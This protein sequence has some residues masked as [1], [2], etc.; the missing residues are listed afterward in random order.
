MSVDAII[1]ALRATDP[2]RRRRAV[3]RLVQ[4]DPSVRVQLL[5]AA[6]GDEDWRVRKEATAAAIAFA[7]ADDVLAGLI[8]VLGPGDN[9]GQRNAAVE[10]LGGFGIDAVEAL[11][12]GM[13]ALDADGRKLG[14]EALGRTGHV[15]ALDVLERLLGDADPNVRAAAIEAITMVG[16]T[17]PERAARMLEQQMSASERIEALSA[18]EGL[19]RLGV[20]VDWARLLPLLSDPVLARPALLAAGRSARPEAAPHLVRALERARATLWQAA[21]EALASL[22][23]ADAACRAAARAALVSLEEPARRRLI[24]A[25][26]GQSEEVDAQRAALLVVGA[27]ATTEAAEAAI[28]A[29]G[30][31]RVAAEADEALVMLGPAAILAL[32]A[33]ARSGE[34]HERALCVELLGRLADDSTRAIARQVIHEAARDESTE[35]VRAALAALGAIGDDESLGVAVRWLRPEAPAPVRQAAAAALA[36]G[37]TRHPEA[38]RSLARQIRPDEPEATVA[39]IVIRTVE[40]AVFGD[41]RA[42]VEF[43]VQA[44]SNESSAVRRAAIEALADVGASQAV[45]AVAFAL[46]DESPDVQL[47]AARTLGR[48]RDEAGGAVGVFHLL[49]VVDKAPEDE[50]AV[51]AIEA[52]GD[53]GDA[54]ALEVL[55]AV[56][57][58][59]QPMQAAV[60]VEAIGRVDARDR[61]TALLEAL[62]HSDPEVVKSALRALA[63]DR[64]PRVDRELGH[65]LEHV[66]WDVRRL[67]ADMLGQRGGNASKRLLRGR[68]A[69][70]VEPLVKEA[71]VRGLSEIEGFVPA[72]R[73]TPPP[74]PSGGNE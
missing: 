36:S 1:A 8:G 56:V 71:I 6:L 9:V 66:A 19:N 47:A 12:A 5:L 3:G 59:G 31:D 39:A 42:D 58:G 25:A 50:L 44:C 2:E 10:A 24:A 74:G 34:P 73:T 41:P 49:E 46:N 67:A 27:L 63:D 23:T 30:D 29:L 17:A 15:E 18:L 4:V 64:D 14:A 54:A 68:L 37:A 43:L 53:A 65:C 51:A 28:A 13:P 26:S 40:M 7:P 32:A 60:A 33:K 55:R 69:D 22:L 11:A 21:V 45:D 48:L 70:E 38:A 57:R 52:L 72:R 16:S 20:V 61:V 62:E 35:V